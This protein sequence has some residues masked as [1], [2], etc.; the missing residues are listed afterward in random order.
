M[1]ADLIGDA[2]APPHILLAGEADT[3]AEDLRCR[4]PRAAQLVDAFYLS[5]HAPS[6]VDWSDVTPAERSALQVLA[7]EYTR[8]QSQIQMAHLKIAASKG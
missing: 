3:E 8:L 2:G 6:A 4:F 1:R 5:V 7:G